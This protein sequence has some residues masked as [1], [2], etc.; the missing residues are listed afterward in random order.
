MQTYL[1]Q[2]LRL[3]LRWDPK[4]RGG[5]LAKDKRPACFTMLDNI[6][7][8]KVS[9][10]VFIVICYCFSCL[11]FYGPV[12]LQSFSQRMPTFEKLMQNGIRWSKEKNQR[13]PFH[14]RIQRECITY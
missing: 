3:M 8:M 2:W 12:R 7:A 14:E 10:F 11:V 9:G 6:L 13:K 1:E 4:A 5:G